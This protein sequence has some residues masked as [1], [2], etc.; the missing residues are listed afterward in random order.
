MEKKAVKT[1]SKEQL[2]CATKVKKLYKGSN[3]RQGLGENH[4]NAIR[5]WN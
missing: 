1:R 5:S 3:C 4:P 2:R